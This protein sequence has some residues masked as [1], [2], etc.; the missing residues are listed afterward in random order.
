LLDAGIEQAL[1]L[2]EDQEMREMFNFL[3]QDNEEE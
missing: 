1:A 3:V 2:P